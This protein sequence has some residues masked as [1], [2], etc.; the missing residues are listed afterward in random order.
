[1]KKFKFLFLILPIY[2][3]YLAITGT[4]RGKTWRMLSGVFILVL[5][6]I[7]WFQF[8]AEAHADITAWNE[9]FDT[10]T[11]G[12]TLNGQGTWSGGS[13]ITVKNDFSNT[14]PNSYGSTDGF[15]GTTHRKVSL[16]NLWTQGTFYVNLFTYTKNTSGGTSFFSLSSTNNN[17][18][19]AFWINGNDGG[20]SYWGDL[21]VDTKNVTGLVAGTWSHFEFEVNTVVDTTRVRVDGGAWSA[22]TANDVSGGDITELVVG[23][24]SSTNSNYIDSITFSTTEWDYTPWGGDGSQNLSEIEIVQPVVGST[25]ASKTFNYQIN[26]ALDSAF[27]PSYVDKITVSFCSLTVPEDDCE[28]D[29]PFLLDTDFSVDSSFNLTGSMTV[30]NGALYLMTASFVGEECNFWL[31]CEDR[32]YKADMVQFMVA[33]T[34]ASSEDIIGALGGMNAVLGTCDDNGSGWVEALTG[35]ALCRTIVYLFYPSDVSWSK[36]SSTV[37]LFKSRAPFGYFYQLKTGV[38]GVTL[39]ASSTP[40]LTLVLPS[41]VGGN[42]TI[43]SENNLRL[44]MGTGTFNLLYSM[45]EWGLWV[46]FGFY[47]FRRV[48]GLAN[49]ISSKT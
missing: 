43:L 30:N 47:I 28:Y 8:V 17:D 24:P 10:Y 9:N 34:T 49:N 44:Y 4:Y 18:Y 12:Q 25:T 41:G 13:T 3:L 16:F 48:Q 29:S 35:G 21:F 22:T 31:F 7:L 5:S 2:G 11:A 15:G 33:T 19:V 6:F 45:V 23:V 1:M 27:A 42:L 38:E 40:G 14:S 26:G 20:S 37:N 32:V 46:T 36:A 39:T